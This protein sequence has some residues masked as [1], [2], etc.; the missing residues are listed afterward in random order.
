M[1][2]LLIPILGLSM[3]ACT[4]S[5]KVVQ[6]EDDPIKAKG[7]MEDSVIGIN[8][9][10]VA[11]IRQERS[12]GD[13]L[14]IQRMANSKLQDKLFQEHHMLKWCRR[15]VSDK[16]LG[17][18][19]KISSIPE[20]DGMKE[21]T[22]VREK[23]GLNADGDFKIVKERKFNDVLRQERKYEKSLKNMIK[24]VSQHREECEQTMGEA[25]V[26]VGLSPE[27]Y[28]GSG[29]FSNGVWIESGKAEKSLSDAFE[30]A[31]KA[32][33]NQKEQENDD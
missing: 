15:D 14:Q 2:L 25:R 17:G 3:H 27:R 13:E 5:D 6:L 32:K 1:K 16:R 21:S 29:Y 23:L 7:K 20:V 8:E 30:V 9:D 22:E 24:V 28:Q 4:S 10:D 31:A 11:V 18:S 33:N 19:G 26:K 12:A